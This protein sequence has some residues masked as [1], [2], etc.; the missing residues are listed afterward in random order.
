MNEKITKTQE[1]YKSEPENLH[2]KTHNKETRPTIE[3]KKHDIHEIRK[4][5]QELSTSKENFQNS[6]EKQP[7]EQETPKLHHHYLTKKIKLDRYKITL[8]YIR[9]NL[10]K[11]QQAFSKLIHQPMVESVS[12][13]GSKTIARPSGILGGG[14]IALIISPIILFIA[15]K[16]GFEVPNS[17]I[18]ILF[19][20]G[21]IFGCF[22]EFLLSSVKRFHKN[23]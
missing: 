19:V 4:N 21:F 20:I 12:E 15:H 17:L 18:I 16:I 8:K 14:I 22:V 5:I 11:R 13:I 1:T 10:P 6:K 23:R 2:K 7:E 9:K 3:G